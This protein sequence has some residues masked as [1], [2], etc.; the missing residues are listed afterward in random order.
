MERLAGRRYQNTTGT[1]AVVFRGEFYYISI[2][3]KKI[4]K[5]HQG[6][7]VMTHYALFFERRHAVAATWNQLFRCSGRDLIGQ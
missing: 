7:Y 3:A 1:N 4:L 6:R 5:N 2:I